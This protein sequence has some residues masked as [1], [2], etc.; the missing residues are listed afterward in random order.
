MGFV[1]ITGKL[2]CPDCNSDFKNRHG[3]HVHQKGVIYGEDGKVDC[4][5]PVTGGHFTDGP[6]GTG[7]DQRHGPLNGKNSHNGALGN[8]QEYNGM[9]DV[10]IE[11]E[12]ISLDPLD[13]FH[14]I[15]GRSLNMHRNDDELDGRTDQ[16]GGS[17]SRIGCCT[18]SKPIHHCEERHATCDM[19][20]V[21]QGTVD[22][23][24]TVCKDDSW[25]HFGGSFHCA[26]CHYGDHGFHVHQGRKVQNDD[27]KAN[28]DPVNT[29]GHFSDGP[30]GAMMGG[31]RFHG[32]IMDEMRHFGDL[33]NIKK[34]PLTHD[35][36]IDIDDPLIDGMT[37]DPHSEH[38]IGGRTMVLHAKNDVGFVDGKPMTFT[39]DAGGR[40][41][42]CKISGKGNGGGGNNPGPS[43]WCGINNLNKYFGV[44]SEYVF[45]CKEGKSKCA[46]KCKD[47][48]KKCSPKKMKCKN[49]KPNISR[50]S[51]C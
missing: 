17:G 45:N 16:A 28:C 9:I 19:V 15:G 49:G 29:L 7:G 34:C 1:K 48:K 51:G 13:F 41:A 10:H 11:A 50:V 30:D 25:M 4:S 21:A 14:Y 46:I 27:G 42:C 3:F 39:G 43:G 37:L 31:T 6:D 22:I 24:E 32:D 5:K 47:G 18:I 40:I 44:G 33:G 20:G 23:T 38:Y 2:S 26:G 8:V 36:N 35:F 12:K